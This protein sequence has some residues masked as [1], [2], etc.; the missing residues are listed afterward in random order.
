MIIHDSLSQL[1]L[2]NKKTTLFDNHCH[3]D[4][5]KRAKID[6]LNASFCPVHLKSKCYKENIFNIESSNY[7]IEVGIN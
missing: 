6:Q 2:I 7:G 1:L 5:Y 3:V 4:T